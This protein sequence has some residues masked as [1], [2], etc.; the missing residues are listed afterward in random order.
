[1]AIKRLLLR[2]LGEKNYLSFLSGIYQRLYRTGL[3][4]KEYEDVY[5][6]K[7]IIRPGDYCADIGA[8]LGYFTIELSRLV[9]ESGKVLA[10]E[11]ITPFHRTLQR[12]LERK[13]AHNVT[14]YQLALGGSGDYVEMGIPQVGA[15]RRFAY[16]RIKENNDHLEFVRS[17][18]VRNEPG[19]HLFLNLPRLDYIKCDVEGFEYQVFASM[20]RTLEAHR[21]MLLCELFDRDLLIRFSTLLQPLG[22]R[23]YLL[24]RGSLVAIDVHAEGQIPPDNYYFLPPQREDRFGAFVQA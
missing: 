22:Y 12:L 7:K 18:K 4:G 11:P 24:E 13:K 23:A 10:V 15:E 14:L 5:F 20:L 6:L 1:M 3:L 2:V 17:E 19:D 21:P 16:A 8:H 9:G